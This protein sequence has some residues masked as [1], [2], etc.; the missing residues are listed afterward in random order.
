MDIRTLAAHLNL[1][2][3]TVSRALN[4]RPDVHPKTRARVRDAAST[5]GYAPNHSGQ[6]LRRG[7][8]GTVA[9]LLA[10]DR[11]APE[12]GGPFFMSLFAGL[13]ARLAAHALDLVV[14]LSRTGEDELAFLRRAVGRGIADGWL[15]SQ[16]HRVDAR[17]DELQRRGI[18]FA[19]LGRSLSG[20]S[21]PW[22]DLDFE[23]LTETAVRRL[24]ERGHRRIALLG[25]A[26]EMNLSHVIEHAFRTTHA[27]AGLPLDEAL[28]LHASGTEEAGRQALHAL[29]SHPDPPTA[30]LI[31][32]ENVALGLYRALRERGL[33]PGR[34]LAIIGCHDTP[35]S[36]SL[37]PSLT[38]FTLSTEAL[39]DA[40]AHALLVA[41]GYEST[42]TPVQTLWPMRLVEGES[43]GPR[44]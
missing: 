24:V 27:A 8:T 28:I 36:R 4:D 19:T 42:G 33:E 14:L 41:L 40:L 38:S 37:S 11:E 35:S 2:I 16:T 17:I 15:I 29:V 18:P 30:I 44:S 5:L 20:G 3:G 39:G 13:Q 21:Q 23:G 25:S 12:H 7:S 9:F 22:L 43:D 10:T 26:R 31:N 6:S 34:D 1:S 32:G